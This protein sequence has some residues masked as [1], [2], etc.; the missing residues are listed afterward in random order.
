LDAI[1]RDVLQRYPR[2]RANEVFGRASTFWPLLDELRAAIPA[3]PALAHAAHLRVKVSFGQGGWAEVP[4]FA[5][6]DARETT[7]PSAGLYLV[8]LVP[9]DGH[10]LILSLNQGSA[11]LIFETRGRVYRVL[12]A[13]AARVRQ[14]LRLETLQERGF[15]TEPLHL[16]STAQFPRAYAAGSVVAKT[17]AVGELPAAEVLDADLRLLYTAYLGL[18]PSSRLRLG[19]VGRAGAL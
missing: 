2:A 8:Y 16:A 9:A 13:R 4:N 10:G 1:L 7:R 12:A 11:D 14:A 18:V 17:Y 3:T 15:T 19:D 5:I 6:M